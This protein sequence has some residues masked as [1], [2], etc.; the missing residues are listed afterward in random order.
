M[1]ISVQLEE[2]LRNSY[3]DFHAKGLDYLCLGR[4]AEQVHKV[5]F[6]DE[7]QLN[8]EVVNPHDHRYDFTT[9]VLAGEL[10][11]WRYE[12]TDLNDPHGVVHERFAWMSPLIGGNGF[13]WDSFRRIAQKS[14]ELYSAGMSHSHM[15]DELHTIGIAKAGTVVE[16]TQGFDVVPLDQPTYTYTKS[17]EP[18]FLSGLYRDMEV[19][20][21]TELVE[22]Y[23]Q[24]SGNI[25]KLVA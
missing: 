12:E 24:L 17:L 23:Q 20:R 7:R 2:V 11:N 13:T 16:I 19:D 15:A 4:T 18:P 14:A 3:C 8:P 25:V 10:V 1:D 9:R 22:L 6:F 21:I 5:Y